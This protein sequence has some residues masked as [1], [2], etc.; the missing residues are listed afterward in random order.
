[1]RFVRVGCCVLVVV[2]DMECG[3]WNVRAYRGVNEDVA[4][5]GSRSSCF[6]SR[7]VAFWGTCSVRVGYCVSQVVAGVER[8]WGIVSMCG[9]VG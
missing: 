5:K 6:R 8:S 2:V 1:M 3:G 9:G 7:E 4:M